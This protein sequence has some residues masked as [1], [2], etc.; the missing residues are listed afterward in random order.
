MNDDMEWHTVDDTAFTNTTPVS[1]RDVTINTT[2][3]CPNMTNKE[4][5]K[6]AM[7]ARDIGVELI[8]RRIEGL[9]RWDEKEHERVSNFFGRADD[10]TKKVLSD[11]LPRLL[12]AMQQLVPEK[13]VRWDSATNR[14]LSCVPPLDKGTNHAAVCK[15]DSEKRVIAIYSAYCE[16]PFGFLRGTC[17]IKTIIHECTHFTDTF[18]SRDWA[19]ADKESSLRVYAL[20]KPEKAIENADSI[21]GYIA[22]FD[23]VIS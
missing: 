6:E 22:N 4:F 23:K 9:A 20:M 21:V 10:A 15:P 11:G 19:Y 17:K 18:N 12:A 3:I 14:M 7:R 2:P 1:N 16:S 13:I 8:K 5:R